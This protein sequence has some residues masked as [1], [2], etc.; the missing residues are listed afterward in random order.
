M[1]KLRIDCYVS[2]L[3]YS[4]PYGDFICCFD[5]L[6]HFSSDPDSVNDMKTYSRY[7]AYNVVEIST[8][9]DL[10]DYCRGDLRAI[11]TI[12]NDHFESIIVDMAARSS[13]VSVDSLYKYSC[14]IN[15]KQMRRICFSELISRGENVEQVQK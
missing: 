14:K 7:I 13:T 9:D 12:L 5:V 11:N 4:S 8:F 6:D 2:G 15:D 10:S 1:F 3:V